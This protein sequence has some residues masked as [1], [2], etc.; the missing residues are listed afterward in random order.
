MSSF[1]ECGG[2]QGYKALLEDAAMKH[3]NAGADTP[4]QQHARATSP[5]RNINH[6]QTHDGATRTHT[7]VVLAPR[8]QV[9]AMRYA[10]WPG[11]RCSTN[12]V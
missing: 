8:A 12:S 1:I 5:H 10:L 7:T 4:R 2:G 11:L 3:R 9:D 6:K